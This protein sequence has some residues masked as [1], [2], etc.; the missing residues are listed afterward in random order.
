MRFVSLGVLSFVVLGCAGG[1]DVPPPETGAP[2][3]EAAPAAAYEVHEWGLL[4]AAAGDVI[5]AG[6]A[7]PP[8]MVPVPIAVDKPVLYFHATAPMQV[9]RVR[10][11]A[12]GGSVREHWPLT[13]AGLFPPSIEW[14]GL[15]LDR[16]G[17][18]AGEACAGAF[19]TTASR[20]CSELPA[21]EDCESSELGGLRAASASCVASGEARLPFLFYRARSSTFTPPLNVTGS[22]SGELALTNAGEAPIPG[23][24]VRIRRNGGQARTIAARAPGPRETITLGAAFETAAVPV[25]PSTPSDES[26]P[27]TDQPALPGSPEPGRQALRLTLAEIGLDEAETEAFLRAWDGPLFGDWEGPLVDLPRAGSD[28]VDRRGP[29]DRIPIDVLRADDQTQPEVDTILYFLPAAACDEVARL[30][31]APRPARVVRALAVWQPAAVAT[32]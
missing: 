27:L 20:P 7:R 18:A 32:R 6:A 23:W 12:I 29:A 21:G 8:R 11:E 13:G 4:R 14:S 16:D 3:V 24:V 10:V 19:P 2:P 9:D 25:A 22:P 28:A 1:R 5:E 30:S 17:S 26:L 15:V 31:F